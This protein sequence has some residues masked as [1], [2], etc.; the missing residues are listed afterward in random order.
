MIVY[1]WLIVAFWLV[2]FGYWA[3]AA[4][5]AKRN[6]DGPQRRKG[7]AIRLSI[8]LLIVLALRIPALRHALGSLQTHLESA[9]TALVGVV[10]CALGT[11][12]ALWA[13]AHLGTNWGMPMSRKEHA[14]LVTTGPYARVRHPIYSGIVLA[15]IG[16]A[17]AMSLIWV[18][19][20]LLFTAYFIYSAR[21][22]EELM[23]R[24]FPHEYP[25]YMKRTGMLVP[26]IA[27]RGIDDDSS[28]ASS[29]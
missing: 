2:L 13:R 23:V 21:R 22:E 26:R 1:R 8:I 18:L 7:I 6:I 29:G 24:L 16:S 11:G 28:Q 19:P 12:I 20:L 17:M 10:L 5:G 27:K 25:A 9:T 14:E 4:I 3:I 15:M